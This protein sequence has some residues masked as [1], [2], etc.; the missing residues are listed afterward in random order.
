[1]ETSWKP[2]YT[3]DRKGAVAA[4]EQLKA[5]KG[6][7]LPSTLIEPKQQESPM[8]KITPIATQY[9]NVNSN[10]KEAKGDRL[11]ATPQNNY[12]K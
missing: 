10:L 3:M 11:P 2:M 1:M 4:T 6:Q 8:R 7:R 5:K 9:S 12:A